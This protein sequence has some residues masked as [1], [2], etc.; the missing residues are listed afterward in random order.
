MEDASKRISRA[1][2]IKAVREFISR[3]I[4]A[5]VLD[6][7]FKQLSLICPV[8]FHSQ[9]LLAPSK[10]GTLR[11]ATALITKKRIVDP[12]RG[13][14][15]SHLE[16]FDISAYLSKQIDK[17]FW[18]CPICQKRL[19]A[20]DLRIDELTSYVLRIELDSVRN[21]EVYADGSHR[22]DMSSAADVIT[23][24]DEPMVVDNEEEEEPESDPLVTLPLS[25]LMD[26]SRQTKELLGRMP[27]RKGKRKA[28]DPADLLEEHLESLKRLIKEAK[29]Q[30]KAAA[31]CG[32]EMSSPSSEPV[33]TQEVVT[34][35]DEIRVQN[36]ELA[37]RNTAL[38]V[39]NLQL[40]RR[41]V[42][43]EQEYANRRPKLRFIAHA[44]KNTVE[45]LMWLD[46]FSLDAVQLTS[47][48]LRAFVDAYL[49]AAPM[50]ILSKLQHWRN[51]S[52]TYMTTLDAKCPATCL[53]DQLSSC[54]RWVVDMEPEDVFRRM[55]ALCDG[56]AIEC[57]DITTD[58]SP[59]TVYGIFAQNLPSILVRNAEFYCSI[60]MCNAL[61]KM[62]HGL[63]SVYIKET[64][65]AATDEIMKACA[66]LGV[67]SLG[68]GDM[69]SKSTS[70][71]SDNISDEALLDFCFS[72]VST[73]GDAQG[74]LLIMD[75]SRPT[76]IFLSKL[77][78]GKLVKV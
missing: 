67:A 29:T 32:V 12:A 9:T 76:E 63:E 41:V 54:R 55:F 73:N 22:R 19:P 17:Q 34:S 50:R 65:D 77:F 58:A 5:G 60:D 10:R 2:G 61:I 59:A 46:R 52:G 43:L 16:C 71:A 57:F 7:T 6:V 21:V 13:V 70:A 40:I 39:V 35:N 48:L 24:D 45:V 8:S 74:R 56:C 68:I 11:I 28:D 26:C 1:D 37:G 15:C 69:L 38:L 27:I 14:N 36:D 25:H 20:E 78:F 47:M 72:D 3:Q 18:D 51:P 53:T 42:E 31:R 33:Q 30:A 44:S 49:P 64:A 4:A 23:L 62:M 75:F 66:K